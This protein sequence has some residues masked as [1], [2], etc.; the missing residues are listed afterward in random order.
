MD[1]T[2]AQEGKDGMGFMLFYCTEQQQEI[3]PA[4]EKGQ[5]EKEAGLFWLHKKGQL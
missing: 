5:A 4:K 2:S 1:G 3:G